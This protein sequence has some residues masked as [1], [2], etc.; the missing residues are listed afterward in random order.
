[1][2]QDARID[3]YIAKAPPFAQPILTHIRAVLHR[4]DPDIGEDIKW[5]MPFFIAH[6][7]PIAN[8]AAFKAHAAFGF[9]RREAAD[10][11]A[12]PSAM[13]QFGKLTNIDD[14][15]P[16]AE[17]AAMVRTAVA[18][19]EGGAKTK[20]V[21]TP[22]APLPVPDDLRAALDAVPAAAAAFDGFPPSAQRE[23]S[24][25]IVEAKQPATRARRLAQAV[26]QCAE[27]KRRYWAMAGR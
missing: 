27:G 5:S 25:W 12:N 23:Y 2:P 9:W 8:M 15:P 21:S 3:A 7:Q 1:M 26:E 20:R 24:E 17:L 19:V 10:A 22:K 4:A 13:G 16:E 18:L 14:L 6:G 11:P